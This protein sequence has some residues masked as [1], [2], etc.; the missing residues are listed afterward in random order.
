MHNARRYGF[1]FVELLVVIAIIG[2]LVALLLPAVQAARESSRRASCNN[3]LHQVGL[4]LH[5]FHGTYNKLP[6][7]RYFNGS[8]TWFA[9]ILPFVEGHSESQAWHFEKLYY[10]RENKQ[11]REAQIPLYRCP[12]RTA[13][14]LAF[15]GTGDS[16]NNSL[17]GAVGDYAG[18]AG[19]NERGGDQY[20][21]PGANGTIITA[22]MFDENNFRLKQ[23]TQWES[24][25]VFKM[26]TDG[27]SNTFLAGEKHIPI[28]A[29]D[30]QGSIYNGDNQ[31][32]CSRVAGRIAPIAYGDQD[33]TLCRDIRNCRAGGQ[34]RCICDTFGSW[35]PGVCQFVFAD[36]HV[37]SISVNTD[38]T[39][40]DRMANR[41]DGLTI[42][43]D[44]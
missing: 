42:S 3:N 24:N 9:I 31:N 22:D 11:A 37:A 41:A 44:Y 16:G 17:R 13:P 12:S 10:A 34:G 14:S 29:G 38:L 6:P 7:S 21:R 43:E 1:T 33:L 5:H 20:W 15:D 39:V 40:I 4:A 18:N 19:S 23:L 2:V 35:H 25:V 26:I 36:G 28:N 27:L 32:N 30:S 8:T